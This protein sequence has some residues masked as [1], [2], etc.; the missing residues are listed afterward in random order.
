MQELRDLLTRW[1]QA[2]NDN[3][4]TA[5]DEE[6]MGDQISALAHRLRQGGTPFVDFGV[7]RSHGTELGRVIKFAAYFPAPTG[8]TP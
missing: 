7:W 4:D 5:E 8:G 3:E 6:A 2:E 1:K